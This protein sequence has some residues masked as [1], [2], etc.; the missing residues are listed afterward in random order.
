[1][2]GTGLE[3][4]LERDGP[5][6]ILKSNRYHDPPGR[7][8]GRGHHRSPIVLRQPPVQVFRKTPV[9]PAGVSD[10]LKK[11]DLPHLALLRSA[12]PTAELRR[13]ASFAPLSG[14]LHTA[15][16]RCVLASHPELP[17]GGEERRMVDPGGI[18]PPSRTDSTTAV[19]R[20]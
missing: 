2:S 7:V 3:V 6:V 20:A 5:F 19:L 4:L 10:A 12:A 11:I 8:L 13:A 18:E 17:A 16:R 15:L 1:M 9:F 14:R